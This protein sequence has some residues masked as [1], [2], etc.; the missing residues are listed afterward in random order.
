MQIDIG[1]GDVIIPAP[2]AI[3]YPTL[4]DFPA[5]VLLAYSKEAVIAEKLDAITVLGLLHSRLKDYYDLAILSRM[6]SFE[7][8][9]LSQAI[10]ATF[11]HR[12]T[13][14]AAQP[15]GLSDTFYTDPARVI[16]WRAFLR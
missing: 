11:H 10:G 3:A 16:Q 12:R 13:H 6:Y 9:R 14:I 5:P 2:A 8:E 7:G 4:L 1:F 15:V